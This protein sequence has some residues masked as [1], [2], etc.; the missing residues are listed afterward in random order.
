[1]SEDAEDGLLTVAVGPDEDDIEDLQEALESG[2]MDPM[3]AQ[4]EQQELIEDAVA[5]FEDRADDES[6][7][8][9]E[10]STE[11][12]GLFQVDAAGDSLIEALK[13]GEVSSIHTGSAYDRFLEQQQQQQQP[14]AEEPPED[15]DSEEGDEEGESEED[16]DD[17]A[18]EGS[19]DDG[20]DGDDG[21][22]E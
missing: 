15:G 8:T 20:D 7:L 19:E 13:D 17:D 2:E 22:D 4:Q 5:D 16:G 14:P 10:E 12:M 18:D 9:I 11:E 3:E 6:E 21:D 1:M